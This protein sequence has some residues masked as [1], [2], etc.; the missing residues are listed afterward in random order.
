MEVTPEQVLWV[1]FLSLVPVTLV[2][3][4]PAL[5]HPCGDLAV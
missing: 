3:D 2:S 4:L 1:K 5:R